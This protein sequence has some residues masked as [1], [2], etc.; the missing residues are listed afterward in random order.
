MYSKSK[1]RTPYW[2]LLLWKQKRPSIAKWVISRTNYVVSLFLLK[3]SRKFKQIL[4]DIGVDKDWLWN[5]NQLDITQDIPGH[6]QVRSRTPLKRQKSADIRLIQSH[7]IVRSQFQ[8]S[9]PEPL[10]TEAKRQ[11]QRQNPAFFISFLLLIQ[12]YIST[13]VNSVKKIIPLVFDEFF[14]I[15]L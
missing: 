15:T 5:Q 13:V 8:P 11:K 9:L 4:T 14:R 10:K 12:V 3:S 6:N 2:N 7:L 1:C